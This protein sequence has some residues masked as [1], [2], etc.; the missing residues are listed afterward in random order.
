LASRTRF[1]PL[2][3][4]D[5]RGIGNSIIA[6][7]HAPTDPDLSG[8]LTSYGHNLIQDTS[9]ASFTPNKQHLADIIGNKL[10]NLGIDPLLKDNGGL[11]KPHTF[12]HAL[13]LGSPAIDTIPL[14]ACHANGNSVTITVDQRGMKRSDG[15]ETFCDIGAYEYVDAST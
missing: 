14:E 5:R 8:K 6:T 7:D 2:S 13:L 10:P 15:T 4:F 11:A 9:G 1:T 3:R 12:T